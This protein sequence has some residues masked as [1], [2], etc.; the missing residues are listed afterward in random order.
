MK[1]KKCIRLIV[2]N[3]SETYL[4]EEIG[5]TTFFFFKLIHHIHIPTSRCYNFIS[6]RFSHL[7]QL[8]DKIIKKTNI[9]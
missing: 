1:V 9:V 8:S 3:L 6:A 2:F 7:C 4:L 5:N